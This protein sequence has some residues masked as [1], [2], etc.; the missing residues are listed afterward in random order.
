MISSRARLASLALT[1]ALG[2]LA[3]GCGGGSG[4]GEKTLTAV[5]VGPASIGVA[6]RATLQLTA[7]GTYSDGST[8]DLTAASTWTSSNAAVATV[9]TTGLLT[10]AAPGT[11]AMTATSSGVSG[12]R[13]A[14]VT[15]LPVASLAVTPPTSDVIAGGEA[16]ALVARATFGDATTA[17]VTPLATWTTSAAG[18][19]DVAGGSVTAPPGAVV[20]ARGTVTASY[21][22]KQASSTLQAVRGPAVV[23]SDTADPLFPEQWHL[24]N[25]GQ[26]A[27]SD[28]AGVMGEDL[29]L[30]S[31]WAL[32]L[33]GRGVKVAVVDDGLQTDHE[34]LAANVVPGS[35]NFLTG[36]S[37]PSP[38]GPDQAH[39]TAVAGITA[40]VHGNK[41][42]GMGIAPGAGLNGYAILEKGF[43]STNRMFVQALGS[44]NPEF[45]DA[46]RSNDVWIFNQSYGNGGRVFS[47]AAFDIE[48][49]FAEGVKSLRSGRGAIYVKSAGNDFD[50][51]DGD[52]VEGDPKP[53]ERA[54]ALR[55]TC[56]NA[57]QDGESSL[58][59]NIVVASLNASG[60]RAAYSSA[61]SSIW[62]SAPGGGQGANKSV[63]PDLDAW[64][65]GPAMVTTDPMGCDLGYSRTKAYPPALPGL[66]SSFFDLGS[67]PDR[68]PRCD[69]TNSM[70]GTSSAAP[71][72]TGAVALLLDAN[73]DLTWRDVKH[74]L[75]TSARRVDASIAPVTTELGNGSYTAELAWTQNAAGRW[76]HNWYGF[77]AVDVAA[78][79][80]AAR[81]FQRGS[82]GT[83]TDTGW[84]M[85]KTGLEL[86]VPDDSNA[87]ATAQLEVSRKVV[88]EAV[89]IFVSITHPYPGDLGI[90]LTS[91]S[92]TRSILLNIQNGLA[93]APGVEAILETNALYGE[94]AAGAWTLK[95]VDGWPTNVG[96]L[97]SW[98]IR[99]YGH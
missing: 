97:N 32:G 35:W 83:F 64:R 11:A 72:T 31:A 62:A 95:V 44:Y 66:P 23:P 5:A 9:S 77:G 41:K 65:Y 49:Q 8:A 76:F 91:P 86:V 19:V 73:P 6:R 53:C 81:V 87:G 28:Q 78:A 99:I 92:G 71:S 84:I 33:T 85:S 4:G 89:Q 36:T 70:S 37:N 60:T 51:I 29:R 39:G 79:L 12:T 69:Y 48:A 17:D 21:G 82:L 3:I 1:T 94:P 56:G 74:I 61:G 22:G 45:P 10:G 58:P 2:V 40:M 20:G 80:D 30:S 96:K 18:L 46:P 38:T 88:V 34:D 68:N 7:T 42:G 26:K 54:I 90:E 52:E 75:A 47:P 16:I 63:N 15:E 98:M 43:P 13:D 27:F 25:T 59:Y 14:V 93:R 50:S 57:S 24:R 55:V 67:I